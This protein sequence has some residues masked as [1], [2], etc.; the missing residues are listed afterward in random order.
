METTAVV[1]GTGNVATHLVRALQQSDVQVLM[2]Y[3]RNREHADEAARLLGVSSTT[4]WK[5]L[6]SGAHFYLY[7]VSDNALAEVLAHT[8]APQAIHLHTAG[9]MGLELFPRHKPRHG[10][11]Y[12]LQTFSKSKPLNFRTVPLFVEA[13]SP[14]VLAEVNRLA[15]L[16]ADKVYEA[17]SQQRRRLHLAAVF[18]CNFVNHLYAIAGDLVQSSHL[19]FEVLRPLIAETASKIDFLSPQE[20]QTGPAVRRDDAVMKKHLALLNDHPEY[21][22]IYELISRSIS[23]D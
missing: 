19:S 3:G 17:D 23:G 6:P 4:D 14:D 7:A 1:V 9:S 12:P 10:V 18:A 11:L 20:A 15:S 16:L 22:K 8:I 21:Q 13:S 5:K 2:L